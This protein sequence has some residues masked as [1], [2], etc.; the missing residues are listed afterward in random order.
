MELWKNVSGKNS[1]PKLI[2]TSALCSLESVQDPN[3]SSNIQINTN[4]T[5]LR[6]QNSHWSIQL[7]FVSYYYTHSLYN[8]INSATVAL[9]CGK[10]WLVFLQ[11]S[12]KLLKFCFGESWHQSSFSNMVANLLR[13]IKIGTGGAES[14]HPFIRIRILTK[15]RLPKVMIRWKK[16]PFC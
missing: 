1:S 16:N 12:S 14:G 13:I 10:T 15:Q 2:M 8:F 3:F 7:W 9:G 11:F 5:K 4:I 6:F